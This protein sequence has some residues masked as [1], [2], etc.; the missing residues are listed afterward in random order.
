MDAPQPDPRPRRK[1]C[2]IARD[3]AEGEATRNSHFES[4]QLP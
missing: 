2:M 1:D 3:E 4:T